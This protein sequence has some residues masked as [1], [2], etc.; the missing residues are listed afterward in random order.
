MGNNLEKV[1]FKLFPEVRLIKEK[2]IEFGFDPVLMS[3]SGA[4]LFC[5]GAKKKLHQ[6]KKCFP[7]TTI[8]ITNTM[9]RNEY[10]QRIGASPS[11]KAPVFGVGIRR[12]ESS[13]PR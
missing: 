9:G 7:G 12:F 3:G 2:M 5:M 10:F 8:F 6:L 4:A 11:G 13:R 1:T